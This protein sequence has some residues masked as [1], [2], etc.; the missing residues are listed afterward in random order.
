M[1]T[2]AETDIKAVKA[3]TLLVAI[4]HNQ[5]EARKE[6]L[7]LRRSLIRKYGEPCNCSKVFGFRKNKTLACAR[8]NGGRCDGWRMPKGFVM[9]EYEAAEVS[10]E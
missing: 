3:F 8:M 4:E 10:G 1:D 6:T 7:N 9:P 5:K 2:D